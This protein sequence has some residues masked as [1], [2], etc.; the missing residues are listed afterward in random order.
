MGPVKAVPEGCRSLRAYLHVR[1]AAQAIDFYQWVFGAAEIMRFAK[2]GRKNRARGTADGRLRDHAGGRGAGAGIRSPQDLGG[3]PVSILFY[4]EDC[5]AVYRKAIDSGAKSLRISSMAT[6]AR[7]SPFG[8]Q[9]WI[10]TQIRDVSA[11]EMKQAATGK[12]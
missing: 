6:A 5:D 8:F 4:T 9:W 3:S 12:A 7:E 1:G 11:D 10:A 2:S